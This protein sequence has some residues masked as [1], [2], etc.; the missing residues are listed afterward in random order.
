TAQNHTTPPPRLYHQPAP[1]EDA[2]ELGIVDDGAVDPA[3]LHDALGLL[4]ADAGQLQKL[5]NV[6]GV[7]GN[8]LGHGVLLHGAARWPRHP[9]RWLGPAPARPE[10]GLE[11]K[12]WWSVLSSGGHAAGASPA[13]RRCR[14]GTRRGTRRRAVSCSPPGAAG[15]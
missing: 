8:S 14:V 5:A 13:C 15:R 9:H 7:D 4:E 2:A 11:S 6:G 10:A 1:A 3:K 12:P